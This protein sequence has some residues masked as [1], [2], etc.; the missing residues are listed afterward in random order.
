[1]KIIHLTSH[2]GHGGDWTVI[3][4][5]LEI[6][7]EKGHHMMLGGSG[8]SST[9]FHA[10]EMPLNQGI[11]GFIRS[12]VQVWHLPRDVD[13]TH[14]HN[15]LSLLIGISFK[16]LRCR[17][18]KIIYTYH[19]Q[20]PDS[21][22]KKILKTLV[23]KLPD[24]IHTCST[25]IQKIIT[26]KYQINKEK[27]YLAYLG[28]NPNRF[29]PYSI[30]EKEASREKYS[31][32]SNAF[33]LLFV[34]RLD[35][36]KNI[37]LILRYLKTNS[38]DEMVLLIAGDGP[39]KE[40]LKEEAIKFKIE[41]RVHFLGRIEEIEEVY[42]LADLLVLPSFHE[43]FGLVIVEAAFCGLPSLRSDTPGAKD[44]I[45]HGEDGF[46]FPIQEPEKM[47]EALDHIWQEREHLPKIGQ[48]AR[49]RAL[50]NF[51]LDKMYERFLSLYQN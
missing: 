50:E 42:S 32:A 30:T 21:K 44:Q 2:V 1:M 47:F 8:A 34:G 27:N 36:E 40:S 48:K 29:R 38:P 5:L 43:T 39:L 22:L 33:I 45:N 17:S 9:K 13:V 24:V 23:F 18:S 14:V 41:N 12:L 37:S 11:K 35:V 51:T 16:Y 49:A 6:F 25:D 10:I 20:T 26:Q 31:L 19:L 28:V 3:R 7:Q 46:I 15:L 4:T